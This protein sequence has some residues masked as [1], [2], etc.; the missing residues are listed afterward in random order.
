MRERFVCGAQT[1]SMP[2]PD[3]LEPASGSAR[4]GDGQLFPPGQSEEAAVHSRSSPTPSPLTTFLTRSELVPFV[5]EL[6]KSLLVS[7]EHNYAKAPDRV[8]VLQATTLLERRSEAD[9]CHQEGGGEAKTGSSR[10]EQCGELLNCCGQLGRVRRSVLLC[11]DE[12]ATSRH[13]RAVVGLQAALIRE[14][15]EQL[16]S[17]DRELASI[18]K[19]R[20]QVRWAPQREVWARSAWFCALFCTLFMRARVILRC[21]CASIGIVA[22]YV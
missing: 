21:G 6:E 19:D 4:N 1:M 20:D 14:Q 22:V 5:L 8:A 18:R 12:S 17:K 2:G 3:T 16:Y 7:K 13:L 15:Q 9:I 10:A 11:S